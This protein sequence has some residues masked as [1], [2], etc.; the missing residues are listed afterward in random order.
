[1]FCATVIQWKGLSYISIVS[2]IQ[3]NGSI[4][5]NVCFYAKYD[6]Y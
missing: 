4:V 5:G 6:L 1:M 2:M 3:I